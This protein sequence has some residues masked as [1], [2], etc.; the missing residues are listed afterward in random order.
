MYFTFLRFFK[1]KGFPVWG[2]GE[3]YTG[4]WWG[5]LKER[6]HLGDIGID[7]RTILRWIFRKWDVGV[8]T[9]SI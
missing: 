8:W 1:V 7:G 6:D 9:G 4:F 2:R 5:N 3:V